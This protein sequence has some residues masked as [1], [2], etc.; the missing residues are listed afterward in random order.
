[1]ENNR[2]TE[3]QEPGS[4]LFNQDSRKNVFQT[5]PDYFERLHSDISSKI[6]RGESESTFKKWMPVHFVTAA[7]CLLILVAAGILFFRFPQNNEKT[8]A[9]EISV[10]DLYNTGIITDMDES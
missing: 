8:A 1:M 6:H 9:A 10:D 2:H 5:P 4:P 3:D 7:A